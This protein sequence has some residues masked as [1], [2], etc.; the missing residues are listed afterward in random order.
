MRI[1]WVGPTPTDDGG[2]TYVGTQ[3]LRELTRAG[4]EVD[5]FVTSP[6]DHVAPSLVEG[7]GLRIFACASGWEWNR[8]Y[9]RTPMLASLSGQASRVRGQWGFADHIADRHREQPY[10]VLYQFSQSEFTPL[11]RRRADLPPIVVHPETHAAGELAWHRRE[12]VLS[13]RC[14][15]PRAR[16]LARATLVVRANLQ[17][18]EL[19]TADRVLGVSAVFAEH[20]IED[21]GISRERVGVV[22]NPIDLERFAFSPLDLSTPD[23]QTVLFISRMSARKGVDLTIALSHRLND[24]AGRVRILMIG[25][26]TTWSD[27]R[28]LLA[29]L[30]PAV[31]QFCG[32]V[33]PQQIAKLYRTADLLVQP[34]QYE[35]F[36]LTVGEALASGVPVV[37][38]DVVGAVDGVDRTVCP[39][40]ER[41]DLAG[42]EAAV[43]S[44]LAR[45]RSPDRA[46][47]RQLARDEAQRL[48]APNLIAARLLD[49]LRMVMPASVGGARVPA[50]SG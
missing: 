40:F 39:V 34:S 49:E 46:A 9:S 19:P 7:D 30:N 8:W 50:P 17:K 25:G 28:P 20:L 48:M 41:G 11:R 22:P 21:Y 32:S 31:A 35:P 14:E 2:V 44:T 36:G 16:A 23:V 38:S 6:R 45:M 3:L 26:P 42:V 5:C 37:A 1:A 15:S 13:R 47:M 4:A 18:R 27:Y 33:A 12:A 43:R 24:L 10:D 29:D